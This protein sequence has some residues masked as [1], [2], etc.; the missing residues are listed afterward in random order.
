MLLLFLLDCIRF[1]AFN[2]GISI[3]YQKSLQKQ[4]L[5]EKLLD[6]LLKFF[7]RQEGEDLMP[8]KILWDSLQPPCTLH[9][10]RTI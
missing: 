10:S 4:I 2:L 9:A 6:L 1:V 7:V 5:R 8:A 3:I